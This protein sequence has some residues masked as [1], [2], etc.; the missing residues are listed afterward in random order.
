MGGEREEVT[1]TSLVRLVFGQ[2]DSTSVKDA[3]TGLT[4]SQYVNDKGM[5]FRVAVPDKAAGA[6]YSVVAQIV[7]PIATGWV[8]IAWG[9][10]MTYNPLA[11]VW[12]DGKNPV[13][14]SRMA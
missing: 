4:F 5:A 7:A 12:L 8:G 11:I 3:E 13:V 10:S 6:A 14:S 1:L 9:G 2:V